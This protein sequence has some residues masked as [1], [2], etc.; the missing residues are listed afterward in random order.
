MSKIRFF[1]C[2]KGAVFELFISAI[3]RKRMQKE[4]KQLSRSRR[5][6]SLR[7]SIFYTWYVVY[8]PYYML[9][10]P[11]DVLPGVFRPMMDTGPENRAFGF[12]CGVVARQPFPH[13][14]DIFRYYRSKIEFLYFVRY[15][16]LSTSQR[17][18]LPYSSIVQ[19]I[20]P[21]VRWRLARYSA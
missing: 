4:K 13:F 3:C 5:R 18:E 7:N 16:P 6:G 1:T 11:P 14:P 9:L 17:N 15:S 2:Y 12:V 21:V 19:L 10:I 20:A 8:C